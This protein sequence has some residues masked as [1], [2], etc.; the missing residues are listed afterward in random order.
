MNTH[1]S[2]YVWNYLQKCYCIHILFIYIYIIYTVFQLVFCVLMLWTHFHFTT[3]RAIKCFKLYIIPPLWM[4]HKLCNQIP[5]NGYETVSKF[6]VLQQYYCE[7]LRH[8]FLF[9]CLG[10]WQIPVSEWNSKNVI[11]W[12]HHKKVLP[13]HFYKEFVTLYFSHHIINN[14]EYYPTF[15]ISKTCKNSYFNCVFQIISLAESS[16]SHLHF[17]CFEWPLCILKLDCWF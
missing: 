4:Y 9:A 2:V 7:Y 17:S 5:I 12:Y 13:I 14:T 16:A 8:R 15:K 3:S 6:S 10:E 11:A 1:N